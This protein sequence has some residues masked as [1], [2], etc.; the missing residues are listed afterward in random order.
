MRRTMIAA[1]LA[2]IAAG[3]AIVASSGAQGQGQGSGQPER[4]IVVY[5][6][7]NAGGFRFVDNRPFTR[8]TRRGPRRIS[9]GDRLV[10]RNPVT[11]DPAFA[12][13]AGTL[14]VECAAMNGSRRFDRVTFLCNGV[15]SL[16]DGDLTIEGQFRPT[17]GASTFYVAVTGG[18]RSYEGR[19]GQVRIDDPA[20][21][22]S[23]DTIHL[24]AER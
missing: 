7:E 20:T 8:V 5:E 12:Q 22:P 21:G 14:H 6:N 23:K 13:P 11:N 15:L 9:M 2:A 1:V 16:T 3:L 10:I 24:V 19:R 4:E 18:T 17:D